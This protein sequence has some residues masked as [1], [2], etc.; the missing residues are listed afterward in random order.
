MTQ[1]LLKLAADFTVQLSDPVAIADTTAIITSNTDDDNV[2]LAN[3]LYGF[4]IDSGQSNKEYIVCTLTGTAISDVH[5]ITR[6]GASTVGFAKAHR[7]GAKVTITDW[8][9]LS[10]MLNNLN[11][12]T[13]F[14]SITPLSYDA[15]PSFTDPAQIPTKDYVD[16]LVNGGPVSYERVVLTGNAGETVVL[17]NLLYLNT[18]DGEW[19][20]TDADTIAT[21]QNVITGIA[22]GAGTNGN[23]IS[24][25][26]L[27]LGLD[28][29]QSGGAAGSLGY[30]GNTAGA[31]VTSAGTNVFRCG[32]FKS[33]T[34][35]YFNPFFY[36]QITQ[37]QIDA[38]AGGGDFGTPSSTNKFVT[39]E[40][41]LFTVPITTVLTSTK[42]G[43][44]SSRY[45]ITLTGGTT[46]RY[47][48]DGNGA[49]PL[50]TALTFPIGT[51]V[52]IQGQNFNAANNGLFT[53]TG[54]GSN[55][56]EVTNASGVAENNGTLGTGYITKGGVWTKPTGLKYIKVQ[57]QGGGGATT[58]DS[59]SPYAD[60]NAGGG[61]YSEKIFVASA[62]SAT[63]NYYVGRGGGLGNTSGTPNQNGARSIFKTLI[64]TGGGDGSTPGTG[65]GGDINI[66]GGYGMLPETT[67]SSTRTFGFGGGSFLG[68]G[69]LAINGSS[70]PLPPT[71]Y[72]GGAASVTQNTSD[73]SDGGNGVIIIT[74]YY[75]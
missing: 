6:Q 34:A 61:G 48:Y 10:R 59:S 3:G 15:L 47:T 52:D 19:Y 49:D 28:A 40:Y 24:G 41:D 7:R 73:G 75:S 23:P 17:G 33:D 43:D 67:S 22:Q 5:S 54:V 63:E 64:A 16:N 21:V 45:D 65:T 1:T 11:G 46:Y 9:I 13:G 29:N 27:V 20:K 69:G 36:N 30:A 71:G 60:Q 37:G 26:V 70:T 14:N 35:F 62:L 2:T 58:G 18:A 32:V 72:G 51:P 38:L 4:T 50:I 53:V 74:E 66:S 55:Y 12:T 44:G 57:V 31:I 39:Q 56:I 42:V 25:G 8:A 68:F